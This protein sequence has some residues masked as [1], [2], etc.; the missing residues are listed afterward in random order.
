MHAHLMMV[1]HDNHTMHLV[2]HVSHELPLVMG[3]V[4]EDAW[5]LDNQPDN[6]YAWK[7]AA[8]VVPCIIAT[9]FI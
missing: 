6:S 8:Q 1:T 2:L 7:P 9:C 3:T 4:S 5:L